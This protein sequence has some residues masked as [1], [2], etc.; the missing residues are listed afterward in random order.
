MRLKWLR[1]QMFRLAFRGC[2]ASDPGALEYVRQFTDS[3][4]LEGEIVIER[5]LTLDYFARNLGK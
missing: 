5:A 4:T 1:R 3:Y 2:K